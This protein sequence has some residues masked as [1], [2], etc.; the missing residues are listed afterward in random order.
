MVVSFRGLNAPTL[1]RV[2]NETSCLQAWSKDVI[3]TSSWI[4][5]LPFTFLIPAKKNGVYWCNKAAT[6]RSERAPLPKLTV[7]RGNVGWLVQIWWSSI[8]W[9]ARQGNW[10]SLLEISNITHEEG[11]TEINLYKL[12]G[13]WGNSGLSPLPVG[14]NWIG[15][16]R[17]FENVL[18]CSEIYSRRKGF[19]AL[20][21]KQIAYKS[22]CAWEFRD[23]HFHEGMQWLG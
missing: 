20:L 17:Q 16:L 18:P 23:L 9:T 19:R 7:S 1:S 12:Y 3:Q 11:C 22:A 10:P 6:A 4:D 8:V 15:S 13:G 5:F 14:A 21:V 2:W